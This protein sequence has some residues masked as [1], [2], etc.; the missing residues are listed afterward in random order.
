MRMAG[1]TL[2]EAAAAA[3]AAVEGIG[4]VYDSP[5]LQ[6]ALPHALVSIDLESDWSHKGSEGREVRLAASLYDKGER[7]LRLRRLAGA[8]EAALG[9]VAGEAEGWRV[10]TMRYLRT[11][12]VRDKDHWAAVIEFRARL[13]AVR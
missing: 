2:L 9:A 11:R 4:R 6:A 12:I 1:E 5:P 3:L 7:P 8:A 10:V 13:L